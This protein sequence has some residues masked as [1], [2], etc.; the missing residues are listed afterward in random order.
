MARLLAVREHGESTHVPLAAISRLRLVVFDCVASVLA[1]VL[2]LRIPPAWTWHVA[3]DRLA[4]QLRWL[5]METGAA[6]LLTNRLTAQGKPALGRKW[7]SF[8][9]VSLTLRREDDLQPRDGDGEVAFVRG[10]PSAPPIV[11]VRV[12]SK[13]DCPR[14]CRVMICAKGV[15]DLP[16]T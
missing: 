9:D 3:V 7:S 4:R 10:V 11:A 13:R 1:P 2:G 14:E 12:E 6:V 16:A 15:V 8:V 5:A